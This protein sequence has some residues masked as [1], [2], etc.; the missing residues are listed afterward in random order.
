M[1]ELPE[2]LATRR[3]AHRTPA[4]FDAFWRRTLASEAHPLDPVFAETPGPLA[5][6]TVHDVSFAGAHG[7]RIAAWLIVP[8][9]AGPAPGTRTR[10]PC[11]VQFLGYG[12]GR[13]AALDWLLWPA[14]GMATLVV[15][16]RGQGGAN[17]RPGNT[18]D[19]VGVRPPQVPGFITRGLLDPDGYY[20]RDAYVDAVRAVETALAHEAVDPERVAVSGCSQGG[21]LALA[22]AALHGRVAAALVESPFLCDVADHTRFPDRQPY[23]ELLRFC[24]FHPHHTDRALTT[25]AHF[26]G[27]AMASR[28]A[29]PAL[30][31]LALRDQ[32]CSP[33]SVAAAYQHYAGPKQIR[34]WPYAGHAEPNGYHRQAEVAFLLAAFGDPAG[35]RGVPAGASRS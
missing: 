33:A 25:L 11:V 16:T 34:V 18:P 1:N 12:E 30:F 9:P 10:V 20:Y 21:L 15:D 13:G 23:R 2:E 31:S 6:A 32:V 5:A 7:H 17:L 22:A 35:V 8:R 19:P 26:D 14:V 4:G 27:V 28:A 29:C 24:Q 3:A